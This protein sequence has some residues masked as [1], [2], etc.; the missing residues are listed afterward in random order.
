MEARALLPRL[1]MEC[2]F[3]PFL[4]ITMAGAIA[5]PAGATSLQGDS[6]RCPEYASRLVDARTH[7]EHG[8]RVSAVR[9]LRRAREALQACVLR[10]EAGEV[11]VAAADTPDH[12]FRRSQ[13]A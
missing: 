2:R 7:L 11:A 9:E 12:M 5:S 3:H 6:G 1:A 8:D 10:E 13:P 4:A